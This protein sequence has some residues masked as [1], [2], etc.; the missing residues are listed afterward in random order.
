MLDYFKSDS[1]YL[2][3]DKS[4]VTPERGDDLSPNTPVVVKFGKRRWKGTVMIT[5]ESNTVS[6]RDI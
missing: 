2:V 1:T 4:K 6:L 5:G 3:L